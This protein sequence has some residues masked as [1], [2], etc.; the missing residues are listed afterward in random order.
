MPGAAVAGMTTKEL[1]ALMQN[2]YASRS[3]KQILP[4]N[5]RIHL[6]ELVAEMP[7]GVTIEASALRAEPPPLRRRV[8]LKA[9]RTAADGREIGLDHVESAMAALA[10]TA[11]GADIPGGRVELRRGNL[12]LLQQKPAPK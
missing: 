10:G 3:I 6:R 8:L 9:L 2:R 7:D 5:L 1:A 12:V 4:A 11:G